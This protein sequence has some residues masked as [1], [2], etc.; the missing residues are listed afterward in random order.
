M[1]RLK[2]LTASHPQMAESSKAVELALSQL[3]FDL[4][5]QT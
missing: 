5:V 4:V 2:N 1:L 3:A